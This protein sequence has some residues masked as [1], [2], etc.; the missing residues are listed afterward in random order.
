LK[1]LSYIVFYTFSVV[2]FCI[3]VLLPFLIY[4]L[5]EYL[6]IN[7]NFTDGSSTGWTYAETDPSNI[8][9]SNFDTIGGN[10]DP[11]VW[12]ADANDESNKDGYVIGA[13]LTNDGAVWSNPGTLLSATALFSY[14]QT[15]STATPVSNSIFVYLIKPD[16]SEVLLFTRS[17]TANDIVYTSESIDIGLGNFSETGTYKIKIYNFIETSVAG[18][19]RVLNYWDDFNL[20]LDSQI[21]A[22]QLTVQSPLNN[23]Y[24]INSVWANLTLDKVGS[25][26]GYSLD[27]AANVS[28]SNSTGNWNSLMSGLSELNHNVTF[29]CNDTY[30]TMNASMV[31]VYFSVDTVYPKLYILSPENITYNYKVIDLNVSAG[32]PID[33]WQYSLNGQSNV[34]FDPNTT[35]TAQGGLNNI[36]LYANDT[37]GNINSTI[38]YFT[39]NTTLDVVLVEPSTTF[40]TNIAQNTTFLVNST[41]F[42]RVGDCGNVFATVRYNQ[43]SIN[44]DTPI[45]ITQ[46]DEPFFIDEVS[47][48]STKPCPTNPLYEGE[49]CNITWI[50]NATDSTLAS[51][52]ID[53]NIS[54]ES[55][56]V[57]Q[58]TTLSSTIEMLLCFVDITVAWT[59]IDFDDPLNPNTYENPALQNDLNYNIT[60]NEG[61]C[62]T[63]LYIKGTDMEDVDNGYVL[64]VGNLTWSNTSNTYATSLNMTYTYVPFKLDVAPSTN[65]TTWYWINVPP[66]FAANYNG[67]IFIQGVKFGDTPV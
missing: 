43:S 17:S 47:P 59:S 18:K 28:M 36:T 30:G 32:E 35:I 11:G 51:W 38:Q 27:G 50:V 41:I 7:G 2:I 24:N 45:N 5:Q 23:T 29:S 37:A 25:W 61:S 31:T 4:S 22:P 21:Y 20:V 3:V 53:V 12:Y 67:T 26:C 58:N 49:S 39:L 16:S 52:V 19:D 64:G 10:L 33:T 8:I 57:S 48:L 40:S 9:S 14:M 63:D 65:I 55:T 15:W 54:S 60:I 66:M 56:W 46:G 1:K 34:T 44:P 42:C 13:N 62:N 6:V